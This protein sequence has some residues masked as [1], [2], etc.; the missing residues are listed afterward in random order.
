[1]QVLEH[2]DDLVSMGYKPHPLRPRTK[3]PVKKGW[4]SWDLE[5]SRYILN[6][7]DDCNLGI[8]LGDIMDVEGD[9]EEANRIVNRMVEGYP[10]PCYRSKKSTHHLFLSP[11]PRI[12]KV[13][14]QKIEFRGLNHQSAVPPSRMEDGTEYTWIIPPTGPPPIMPD[15]LLTFLRKIR[16]KSQGDI[17][18]GHIKLPCIKCGQICFLHEKRFLLEIEEFRKHG[19]RWSCRKCRELDLRKGCRQRRRMP[20]TLMEVA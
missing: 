12:T 14:F 6:I 15:R 11:D 1:M 18:P 9:S 16:R 7:V 19:Q 4:T 20:Y 17:K 10:H 13:E 3:I 5:K 8:V 2:F